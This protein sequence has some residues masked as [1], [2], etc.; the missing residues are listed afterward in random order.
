MP[1]L[2]FTTYAIAGTLLPDCTEGTLEQ[3]LGYALHLFQKRKYAFE[4]AICWEV[5]RG[6]EM[7]KDL[8]VIHVMLAPDGE[9]VK[10]QISAESRDVLEDVAQVLVRQVVEEVLPVVE[11]ETIQWPFYEWVGESPTDGM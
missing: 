1:A 2:K 9:D 6:G 11:H 10:L 3:D 4:G 8:P 5:A 7:D